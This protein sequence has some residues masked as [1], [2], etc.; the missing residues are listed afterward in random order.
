MSECADKRS[1]T[2]FLVTR[3]SSCAIFQLISFD[4]SVDWQKGPA[5][6]SYVVRLTHTSD[7]CPTANSKVRE[8]VVRG[9]P[10]IPNLA[11]K[12]GVKMV[13]GPLVLASEHEAVAVVEAD[14]VET[15]NE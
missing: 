13:T 11:A 15:V 4:C 9:A 10:E 6:P 12:L 2:R 5:M 8:R 7:Q 1:T 14:S 3:V